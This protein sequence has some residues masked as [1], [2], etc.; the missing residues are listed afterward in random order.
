M[1]KRSFSIVTRDFLI[2]HHN[3][4]IVL[5]RNHGFDVLQYPPPT[6]HNSI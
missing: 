2:V 4:F 3:H 6:A 5:S 1:G